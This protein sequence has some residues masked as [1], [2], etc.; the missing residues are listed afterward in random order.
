MRRAGG[1]AKG[2]NSLAPPPFCFSVAGSD[3]AWRRRRAGERGNRDPLPLRRG[4]GG[5]RWRGMGWRGG[6]LAGAERE[7]PRPHVFFAFA[8]G[9]GVWRRGPLL[10][11]RRAEGG[12]GGGPLSLQAVL[13]RGL[14]R[15]VP[16]GVVWAC[17]GP[18]FG[19]SFAAARRWGGGERLI[20][21]AGFSAG[22]PG[23][24]CAPFEGAFHSAGGEGC[25]RPFGW[26]YD[27]GAWP[28]LWRDALPFCPAGER[29]GGGEGLLGGLLAGCARGA[30]RCADR[31]KGPVGDGGGERRSGTAAAGSSAAGG[32]CRRRLGGGRFAPTVRR[33]GGRRIAY[34]KRGGGLL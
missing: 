5:M 12:R 28:S 13:W 20:L 32:R 14:S 31:G 33:Q 24:F 18:S 11:L 25:G 29:L 26:R 3:S 10:P 9:W 30:R 34:G 17:A 19:R 22:F 21:A 23:D 1:G 4:G 7:I 2:G 16:A 6:C 15:S 8:A 27:G